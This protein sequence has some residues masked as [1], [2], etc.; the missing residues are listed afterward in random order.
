MNF[1]AQTS[2]QR[3]QE[4]I[5]GKLE[6][7]RKTILG[8]FVASYTSVSW[9]ACPKQICLQDLV[10]AEYKFSYQFRVLKNLIDIYA[11]L[12]KTRYWQWAVLTICPD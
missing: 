6:K 2:S 5:E 12:H 7:K 3:V 4:I 10:I 1:S 9:L 11:K 8:E